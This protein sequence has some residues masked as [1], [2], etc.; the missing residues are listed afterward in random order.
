M[1]EDS[2]NEADSDR[3]SEME[4]ITATEENKDRSDEE[5]VSEENHDGALQ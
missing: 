4:Q 1:T 5:M 3:I 2:G